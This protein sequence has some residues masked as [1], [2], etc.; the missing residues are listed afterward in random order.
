MGWEKVHHECSHFK[1]TRV[2]RLASLRVVQMLSDIAILQSD[3]I[4]NVIAPE[5]RKA[6]VDR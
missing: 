6:D 4:C 3:C 1:M 5:G 2:A